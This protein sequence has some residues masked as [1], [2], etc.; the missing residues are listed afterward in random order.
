[1][2]RTAYTVGIIRGWVKAVDSVRTETPMRCLWDGGPLWI[3]IECEPCIVSLRPRSPGRR[4]AWKYISVPQFRTDIRQALMI[5]GRRLC[6][7]GISVCGLILSYDRSPETQI[8]VW[9]T[10]RS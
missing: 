7:Y 1:M 9:R 2:V 6:A 4:N 5:Q 10:P 8:P 3:R